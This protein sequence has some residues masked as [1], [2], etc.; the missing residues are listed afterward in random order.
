MNIFKK[1]FKDKEESKAF[2][3]FEENEISNAMQFAC[4]KTI[5]LD[6]LSQDAYKNFVF[7][8]VD[9]NLNQLDIIGNFLK[10]YG[11]SVDFAENGQKGLQ[12]YTD[13]PDK[14]D[15]IFMDIQ[16]PIMDGIEAIKRIRTYEIEA[17]KAQIKP[18]SIVAVSGNMMMNQNQEMGFNFFLS[19]PFQME[20]LAYVIEH[21]HEKQ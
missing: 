3:R 7:L 13:T 21:L 14:Y 19:K 15:M 2:V 17:A 16:M 5:P 4:D 20:Q 9:D 1:L 18:I 8:V 6:T 11:A 10:K 12:L